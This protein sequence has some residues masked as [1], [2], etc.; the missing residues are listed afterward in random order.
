MVLRPEYDW[1]D[2]QRLM[3][4]F[5][6]AILRLAQGVVQVFLPNDLFRQVAIG[7]TQF[8][9]LI[10]ILQL[11]MRSALQFCRKTSGWSAIG[12]HRS[13]PPVS[14]LCTTSRMACIR[15]SGYRSRAGK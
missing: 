15:P 6:E 1:G 12:L 2:V 7:G 8:D 10:L 4:G 11:R 3:R 9:Q 14:C 13:R 5:V